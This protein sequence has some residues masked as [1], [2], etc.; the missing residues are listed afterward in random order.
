MSPRL[1]SRTTDWF[2]AVAAIV[3]VTMLSTL[4]GCAT[5]GDELRANG[6][7]RGTIAQLYTAKTARA[8]LPECLAALPPEELTRRHFVRVDYKHVRHLFSTVAE[9]AE[10]VDLRTGQQV[11]VW[12]DDC[13][14]GRFGR[15]GRSLDGTSAEATR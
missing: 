9:V 10:G 5:G 13:A 8:D 1:V 15:I 11:E 14:H 12:L 3:T 7:R 2:V 6:A 4:A